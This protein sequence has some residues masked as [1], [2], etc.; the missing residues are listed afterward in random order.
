M[1]RRIQL[2]IS[3]IKY[4]IS[5]EC[6][7]LFQIK[8][9]CVLKGGVYASKF[10]HMAVQD[11]L[12]NLVFKSSFVNYEGKLLSVNCEHCTSTCLENSVLTET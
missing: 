10:I 3:H 4:T 9:K 8:L 12:K 5:T 6:G 2:F 1:Y 11:Q 7:R